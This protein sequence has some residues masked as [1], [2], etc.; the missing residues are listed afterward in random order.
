MIETDV[1]CGSLRVIGDHCGSLG[2]GGVIGGGGGHWGGI[3]G[4][5]GGGGGGSLGVIA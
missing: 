5:G 1:Y 3:G 2:A 4:G